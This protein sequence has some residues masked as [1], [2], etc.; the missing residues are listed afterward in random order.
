MHILRP[1]SLDEYASWLAATIPIYAA[2]KV[3][4]GQWTDAT[5]IEQSTK[6]YAE[7]LPLGPATPDNHLFT[8]LDADAAAMGVL[9]FAV[10]IRFNAR[11]AY[12]FDVS[13]RP[14]RQRQG[15][16]RRAFQALDDEVRRLGLA[17]IALHVFGHNTAA[18]ALYDKLGFAATSISLYKQ[19][20]AASDGTETA[21]A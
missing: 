1:I 18:R 5:S 9:W 7:L 4:S 17:G 12:V 2:E 10:K 19:V 16:A 11:I 14:E 21:A 6:E 15:H 13:I 8:I 3:A 20:D